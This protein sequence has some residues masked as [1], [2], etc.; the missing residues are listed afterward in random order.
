MMH[1]NNDMH[2][3]TIAWLYA[4]II[5]NAWINVS[6]LHCVYRTGTGIQDLVLGVPATI[7]Y[8]VFSRY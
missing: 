7:L 3:L 2:G 4:T 5:R 8:T 6:V 1:Y